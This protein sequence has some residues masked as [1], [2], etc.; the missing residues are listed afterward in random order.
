[1]NKERT[2]DR[3]EFIKRLGMGTAAVGTA[4]LAGCNSNRTDSASRELPSG[5][6]EL[7]E[8][9][10]SGDKVS[11]LGYGCMRWPMK[12][13]KGGKDE[14]DQERINQLVDKALEYGVNYFDTAPVYCQGL[15]ERATGIA[16]SRHPRESYYLATKMSNF[17]LDQQTKEGSIAMYKNSLKELQTDYIDYMLLHSIG[18]SM[19]GYTKRFVDSGILEYLL[20]ERE[21]GRVRN[22]GFSFHG[23]QSVFDEMMN[24]HETVHW[25]FV[26][27]QMNYLDWYHAN[28]MNSF[29]VDASYL[30]EEL[31]KRDIPVVIMEP[32]LGGRLSK[33]NSH[34]LRMLKEREPD[35]TAAS[36]AFRYCASYPNVLTALS[37]MTYME[38]LED[39][40]RSFCPLKPLSEEERTFLEDQ[41]ASE[42]LKYPAIPCTS[43]QYCMPCPYGLDIPGIFSHYNKCINEDRMPVS[44]ADPDYAEL[45]KAFLVGYDRSVPKLRQAS[46]CI[47]CCR[48][49]E[50]CPQHIEI[51]TEMAKIDDFVEHLKQG[52]EM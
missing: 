21:E 22:L 52:I 7:R 43:C 33:V 17:S 4:A 5:P 14:L 3:R 37:G 29:N 15:S 32:L 13:G 34:V 16:L 18:D 26:Q 6:M 50:H 20:K 25:D 12:K 24:L 23:Q 46:H 35:K 8:N 19:E 11:V 30:Y 39:N 48:C 27:I 42:I 9:H 1:M 47:E 28:E 10:N 45:R 36:W 2:M 31:T 44:P 40:L 38:H 51:P 49:L 41:V